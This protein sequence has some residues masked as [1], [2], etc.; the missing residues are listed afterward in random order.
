MLVAISVLNQYALTLYSDAG[1]EFYNA[2][3]LL[4]HGNL[5]SA[6]IVDVVLYTV[7]FA[8]FGLDY[9]LI[10]YTQ[11]F[12]I[13]A[14]CVLIF[15]FVV[16]ETSDERLSFFASS[17]IFAVSSL[18]FFGV[19]SGKQYPIFMFFAF[20]SLYLLDKSLKEQSRRLMF[21]SALSL[22]LSYMTHILSTFLMIYPVLYIFLQ[23]GNI[24][25][26]VINIFSFYI[27]LGCFTAPYILWRFS[28][29]GWN[30]YHYPNAWATIKYGSILNQEYWGVPVGYTW[31]YYS[32]WVK[33]LA[34]VFV[35]VGLILILLNTIRSQYPSTI[36]KMAFSWSLPAAIPFIL[37]K[38]PTTLSYLYVF[39]PAIVIVMMLGLIK[40]FRLLANKRAIKLIFVLLIIFL[41][42]LSFSAA[43]H[44]GMEKG[45]VG[46]RDLED[47]MLFSTYIQY[48]DRVLFRSY[49]FAPLIPKADF[50]NLGKD[51][52]E[53]DAVIYINWTDESAV[54]GMLAK[55]NISF[56]ILYSSI[57]KEIR[58]NVWFTVAYGGQPRHVEG[59]EKSTYF[60][61]VAVGY[62]Y[63]LIR[64]IQEES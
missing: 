48:E 50:Y 37:S 64:V 54:L 18:T 49:Y 46:A 58:S 13:L 33:I 14:L 38:V 7:L 26:R 52:L 22:A 56:I 63:R 25:N 16:R 36:Y 41:S 1:Y 44:T 59:I 12:F 55:Y 62:S 28:I 61:E 21:L 60:Q 40:Y 5:E 30:F 47:A 20:L 32:T 29:D 2:R 6:P 23:E 45:E 8:I 3:E 11:A 57:S 10:F 53:E 27:L 34:Q 39:Y 9:R 43:V 24:K 35:P 4:L 42:A 15:K 19:Q 17:A 51:V 31:E